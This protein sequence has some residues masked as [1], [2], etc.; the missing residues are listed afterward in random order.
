[1]IPRCGIAKP[2]LLEKDVSLGEGVKVLQG[3]SIGG[4]S[5]IGAGSVVIKS[6]SVNVITVGNRCK[7]IKNLG[8]R[9]KNKYCHY[10]WL[11]F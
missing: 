5:V 4:N 1:M 2:V 10:G 11:L 8:D 9:E 3:I 6:I 7:V